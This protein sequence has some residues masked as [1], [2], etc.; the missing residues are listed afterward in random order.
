MTRVV[1]LVGPSG[2]GKSHRASLVA[3]ERGC[4]AIIDDGLL[5]R[6]GK[7]L[8]GQSAKRAPSKIEA[9][10]RAIFGDEGHAREVREALLQS[11][12]ESLLVLGTSRSMVEKIAQTLS[13]PPPEIWVNIE[14][15]ADPA[16]IRLAQKMRHAYGR[17]VIPAPTVEVRKTFSGYMVDPL[18]FILKKGKDPDEEIVIEKSVVRPTWSYLG[19]F[20]VDDTVVSSIAARAALEVAGVAGIRRV[21]VESFQHGVQITVDVS[22]YF[23]AFIPSLLEDVRRR[24]VEVVEHMTALNVL[25]VTAVAKRVVLPKGT[26]EKGTRGSISS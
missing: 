15:L 26:G 14:D 4:D 2:T 10:R 9:I 5:I 23:G 24:V 21:L 17:H 3:V 6:E 20:T 7:I 19:R 22:V 25:T 18:R 12:P 13:L 8:A 11:A 16:Q 1:G